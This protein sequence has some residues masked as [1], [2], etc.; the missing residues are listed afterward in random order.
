MSLQLEDGRFLVAPGRYDELRQ[1]HSESEMAASKFV[2]VDERFRI[3][4]LGTCAR[5]SGVC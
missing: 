2:R 1:S 3:I 4:A 5:A